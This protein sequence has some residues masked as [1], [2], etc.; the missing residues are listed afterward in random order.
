MV[1]FAATLDTWL[2]TANF[3]CPSRFLSWTRFSLAIT[4]EAVC[5]LGLAGVHAGGFR[6]PCYGSAAIGP[7]ANAGAW[8]QFLH[9]GHAGAFP[10]LGLETSHAAPLVCKVVAV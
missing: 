5:Q 10:A 9:W 6:F 7:M 8:R 2:R 3:V 1:R 4:G